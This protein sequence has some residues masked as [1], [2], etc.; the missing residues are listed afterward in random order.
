MLEAWSIL[1]QGYELVLRYLNIISFTIALIATGVTVW[2]C[3]ESKVSKR[4]VAVLLSFIYPGLG[5]IY[6]KQYG[7]G[8]IY[9]VVM[10]WLIKVSVPLVYLHRFLVMSYTGGTRGST[11]H[12]LIVLLIWVHSIWYVSRLLDIQKRMEFMNAMYSELHRDI[13]EKKKLK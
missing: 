9:M 8:V 4:W 2:L 5:H 12:L 10:F 7:M 6:I 3:R 1:T 11:F 13:E